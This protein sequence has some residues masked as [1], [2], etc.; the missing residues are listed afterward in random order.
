MDAYL[1]LNDGQVKGAITNR[2]RY[3]IRGDDFVDPAAQNAPI[4]KKDAKR[5]G[6]RQGHAP[7]GR[8]APPDRIKIINEAAAK[9]RQEAS[10]KGLFVISTDNFLNVIGYRQPRNAGPSEPAAFRPS[11]I[12]TGPARQ[13]LGPVP[14]QPVPDAANPGAAAPPKGPEMP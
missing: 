14:E 4:K 6:R 10:D 3:L 7:Q 1:D 8:Q 9:M 11:P 5:R 2:T 12:T 13:G